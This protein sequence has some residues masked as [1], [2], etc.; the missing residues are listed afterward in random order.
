M[1][2]LESITDSVD[3]NLSKLQEMVEDRGAWCADGPW[4]HR[5][6]HDLVNASN[7][8]AAFSCLSFLICFLIL[9]PFYD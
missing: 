4:G 6:E 2:W 5:A 7:S 1:R 3:K 9:K 8:N